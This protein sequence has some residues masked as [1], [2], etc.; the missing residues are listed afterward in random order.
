[1]CRRV[2][3]GIIDRH[4]VSHGV[5]VR[6]RKTLDRVKPVRVRHPLQIRHPHSFV[7]SHCIDDQRVAFKVPDAVSVIT[8][9]EIAWMGAAIHV[10]D[11]KAVRSTSLED[12][13]LLDVRKMDKMSSISSSN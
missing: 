11:P 5:E 13:E 1:P 4:F 7:V 2:G 12:D 9:R 8:R 3:A 10:N 6:T